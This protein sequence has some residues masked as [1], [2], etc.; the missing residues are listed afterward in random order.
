M[1]GKNNKKKEILKNL[2]NTYCRLAPSDIQGVGVFAIKDIPKGKNPFQMI[3]KETWLKFN[4]SELKS[5]DKEAL[6]LVDDFF[7]VGKNGAVYIPD[8]ALNGINISYF[9]NN[10]EQPNIKTIDDG[11][12]FVALKK[13]KKGE[14][15]TV[16]YDTYNKLVE[17]LN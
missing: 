1:K 8:L 13:I 11:E 4:M 14:E 3:K 7:V 15:L 2:K 5:L 17:A 10:S 6:K 16:S 12:N 9:L